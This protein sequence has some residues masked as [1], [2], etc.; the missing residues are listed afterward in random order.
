MLDTMNKVSFANALAA[1][2]ANK[3]ALNGATVDLM[4]VNNGSNSL[5]FAV[6]AGTITD[7]THTF[8]LQDSP[9]GTTWNNVNAPFVLIGP[10]GNVFTAATLAGT[11]IKL[12]YLGNNG[13]ASRYVRVVVAASGATGGIYYGVAQLG[14]GEQLLPAA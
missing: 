1:L 5:T 4:S 11:V 10:S 2:I 8:T 12:G 13:G 9:D 6:V 7:G 3:T 14:G